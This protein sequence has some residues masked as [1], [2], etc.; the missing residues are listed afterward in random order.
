[1]CRQTAAV[2]HWRLGNK[3]QAQPLQLTKWLQLLVVEPCALHAFLVHAVAD[4]SSAV[5]GLLSGVCQVHTWD[6]RIAREGLAAAGRAACTDCQS[7]GVARC[8]L[9]LP[10]LHAHVHTGC[11]AAAPA[12]PE[13]S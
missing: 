1:M 7:Q 11:S 9:L 6:L 4:L 5:S 13:K 8:C 10:A 12:G 2:A 3:Q